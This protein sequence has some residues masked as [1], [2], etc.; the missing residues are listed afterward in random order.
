MSSRNMRDQCTQLAGGGAWLAAIEVPFVWFPSRL[1]L[2]FAL[3]Q[4]QGVLLALIPNPINSMEDYKIL[5]KLTLTSLHRLQM[6]AQDNAPFLVDTYLEDLSN[7]RQIFFV[8]Y[9]H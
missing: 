2:S 6:R 5:S 1:L 8:L 4:L 9:L 7:E 3:S